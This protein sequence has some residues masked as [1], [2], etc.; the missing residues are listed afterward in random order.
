MTGHRQDFAQFFAAQYDRT[1]ALAR[2][3]GP[4]DRAEDV[5]A[6]A[7]ERVF[8]RWEV[9]EAPTAY[10][11][12]TV[13]NLVVDELRRRVRVDVDDLELRRDPAT[14]LD[15]S[16]ASGDEMAV[17]LRALAPRQR[18]AVYLRYGLDL[19][20]A[21]VARLMGVSAGTVKS[22]TSRALRQLRT[23]VQSSPQAA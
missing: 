13:R 20:E 11:H 7:F 23:V 10:L 17:A 22:T 6:E 2:R 18:T 12:R 8:R 4:R 3:L 1:V 19:S 14:A 21:D 5:A 16:V 15:E 9:V